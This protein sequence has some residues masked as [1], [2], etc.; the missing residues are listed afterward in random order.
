METQGSDK[1]AMRR[2]THIS[3]RYFQLKMGHRLVS[4]FLKII[5]KRDSDRCWDWD[6]MAKMDVHHVMFSCTA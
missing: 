3:Q 4:T 6:S 2:Q 1:T 5:G